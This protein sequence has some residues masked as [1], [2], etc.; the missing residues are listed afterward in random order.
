MTPIPLQMPLTAF[1]NVAVDVLVGAALGFCI[2]QSPIT[3]QFL[4]FMPLYW[5]CTRRRLDAW[6]FAFVYYLVAARGLPSGASVFFGSIYP[7]EFSYFLYIGSSFALSLPWAL[8]WKPFS[9]FG[10]KEVIVSAL[11]LLCVFIILTVVPLGLFGWASPIQAA[12]W[13]F[14]GWGFFGIAAF[15][16]ITSALAYALTFNKIPCFVLLAISINFLCSRASEIPNFFENIEVLDTVYGKLASGSSDIVDATIRSGGLYKRILDVHTSSYIL[17]PET[18]VGPWV[19]ATKQYWQPVIAVLKKRGQSVIIG[20]EEY[21]KNFMYDN[22]LRILGADSGVYRQR[23][24]VPI[25]MWRPF[26]GVGTAKAHWLD[27]GLMQ[28]SDG[29]LAVCLVCY[30]Q[31]LPLP[32]FMSLAMAPRKPDLI[33]AAENHW[34]SR[35]T[36]LPAA[37]RQSLTSWA[38][39]FNL[40]FVCAKNI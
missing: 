16:F 9:R 21:D 35:Q 36:Y 4:L 10:T 17:T 3:V 22:T 7:L 18:V 14:K 37:A 26:G 33:I 5:F 15:C 1:R 40:P 29:R 32:V 2:G 19:E 38:M 25:S 12:G 8:V 24:P 11:R 28:L 30:E 6:L 31:Y 13:I 27:S 39:L 20:S 23:F 34:W